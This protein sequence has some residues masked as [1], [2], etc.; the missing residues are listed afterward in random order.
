[1]T[2]HDVARCERAVFAVDISHR[3]P[4]QYFVLYWCVLRLADIPVVMHCED[5][6]APAVVEDRLRHL[7]SE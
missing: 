1:M 3:P 2:R 5:T 4:L 7:L 6:E